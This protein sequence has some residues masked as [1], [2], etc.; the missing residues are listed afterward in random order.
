MPSPSPTRGPDRGLARGSDT[1]KVEFVTGAIKEGVDFVDAVVVIEVTFFVG[2]AY[3][4]FL[5]LLV[6][7]PN[8]RR[9]FCILQ[10]FD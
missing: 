5:D 8:S 9:L 7:S 1:L 4:I 2:G 6:K 10:S 3:K